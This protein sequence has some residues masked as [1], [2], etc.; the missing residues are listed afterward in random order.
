[1]TDK[2][3]VSHST[4]LESLVSPK[5]EFVH[6]LEVSIHIPR[7]KWYPGGPGTT[8]GNTVTGTF[9]HHSSAINTGSAEC[10]YV[11]IAIPEAKTWSQIPVKACRYDRGPCLLG[12]WNTFRIPFHVMVCYSLDQWH[13]GMLKAQLCFLFVM[14]AVLYLTRHPCP[15]L[16]QTSLNSKSCSRLFL[17]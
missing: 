5:R 11:Y 9:F 14:I 2:L 4:M 8:T 7:R 3:Y 13:Q 1:M 10:C 17:F 12:H 16:A 6:R 15:R